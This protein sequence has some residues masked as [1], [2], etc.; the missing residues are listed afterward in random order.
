MV[1]VHIYRFIRAC[2]LLGHH[3][4]QLY[5]NLADTP[6]TEHI[7]VC[8]SMCSAITVKGHNSL[9]RVMSSVMLHSQSCI[10][11]WNE[12]VVLP[13]VVLNCLTTTTVLLSLL[14]FRTYYISKVISHYHVTSHPGIN[15]ATCTV[16]CMYFHQI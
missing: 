5:G 13:Y 3:M 1:L 10:T 8:R 9:V 15:F 16:I 11:E 7:F 6:G 4:T 14:N 12:L 2:S